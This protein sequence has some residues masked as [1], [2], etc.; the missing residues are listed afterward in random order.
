MRCLCGCNIFVHQEM[1][2][3]GHQ[4]KHVKLMRELRE[5]GIGVDSLI[6]EGQVV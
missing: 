5:T 1:W 4:A 2:C 6:D 3:E